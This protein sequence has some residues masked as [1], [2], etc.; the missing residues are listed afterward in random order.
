MNFETLLQ[1][2]AN[3]S[4]K[5]RIAETPGLIRNL[6]AILGHSGDSWY[7]LPILLIVSIVGNEFWKTRAT[8]LTIAILATAI[9]VM[10][11]KFS[12]R[13]KR[14]EGDWGGIYRKTDPHSFPSGHAARALMLGVV[15]LGIGPSWFGWILAIWGPFVGLARVAMG[16]HYFSD[17]LAGWVVGFGLGLV[18]LQFSQ[19]LSL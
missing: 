19:L 14:P 8:I 18:I 7:L 2:D 17:V 10:I 13:R 4:N 11:L 1:V 9:I 15:G 5:L 16:V 3:I 12:I 6:S